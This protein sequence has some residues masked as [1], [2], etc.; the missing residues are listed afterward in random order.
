VAAAPAYDY[1]TTPSCL[2]SA[3]IKLVNPSGYTAGSGTLVWSS[4][5]QGSTTL[6]PG[7]YCFL[8]YVVNLYAFAHLTSSTT[9]YLMHMNRENMS[10][11]YFSTVYSYNYSEYCMI[12]VEENRNEMNNYSGKIYKL[13]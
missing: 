11:T 1:I 3:G 13:D 8:I 9:I 7:L 5:Y 4:D 6:E 2:E 10:A 12:V